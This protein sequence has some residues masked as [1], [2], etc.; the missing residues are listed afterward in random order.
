MNHQLSPRYLIV[1]SLACAG[2]MLSVIA[3][4]PFLA[5]L[6]SPLVALGLIGAAM[7]RWPDLD[8]ELVVPDRV[9]EGDEIDLV[10]HAG[11]RIGIPWLM[12]DLELP[13]DLEPIQGTA[14]T[15]VTIRPGQLVKV[16]VPVRAVRWGVA[17]P[18]RIS[19]TGRDRLG[20]FVSSAVHR[21]NKPIRV[22]PGDGA[23]HT[24]LRPSRLRARVG[25]HRSR[26]HGEGSDFA[27]IRPYRRGDP[28]RSINWRVSARKGENWVTVRHPDRSGDLV[29]LLDTFRDIGPLG[30]RLVQRA[31]RAA[32]ALAESN[33]GKHDRVGLLDVGR[34]IRWYRPRLGR[35]HEARLIDALLDTQVEPGLRAHHVSHL[36]LH[37][38]DSGTL[39]VFISGLLD[40]VAAQLPI[41]LRSRGHEVV[42]LECSPDAHHNAKGRNAELATRLWRLQRAAERKAMIERGVAVV[43]W[44]PGD[45]L[46]IPI[47]ALERRPVAFR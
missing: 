44:K 22:H 47:A 13:P 5:L 16:K 2:L 17:D 35:L 39:I 26:T 6:V 9:V 27:E 32:L 46:E 45:P 4:F 1:I 33:L 24:V 28:Q 23:R 12:L 30:D 29:L 10:I 21:P 40:E 14:R 42:V 34:N 43:E 37:D 7:H 8:L 38:L 19:A 20:F 25:N 18:G 36:P 11:S 31:V 41:E 15:I 3:G